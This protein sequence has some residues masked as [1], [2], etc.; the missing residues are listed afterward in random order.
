MKIAI[1]GDIHAN[2][3]ALQT[4]LADAESEQVNEYLSVGDIV[5]YGPNPKECLHIIRDQLKCPCVRGN[6]DHLAS[7]NLSTMSFNP[8]AAEAIGWTREQLDDADKKFLA[9]L[10]LVRLV[11]DFTLVHATLDM[12]QSWGYVFDRLAAASSMSYQTTSIC[13][14]GHTHVPLAF[15][16]EGPVRTEHG[17]STVEIKPGCRYFINVGSIGQPRDGNPKTSYVIYDTDAKRIQ[18]KRLDYDIAAVQYK[19][20]QAGL[21]DKLAVRLGLGK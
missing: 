1:L 2:L 6:H 20:R 9:D 19:I 5:G 21:P 15:I 8:I 14:F 13:F 3:E 7:A 12:P 18:I 11:H 4:V 17:W 10:R 16:K